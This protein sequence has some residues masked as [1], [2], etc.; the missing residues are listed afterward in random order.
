MTHVITQACVK[1]ASCVPVCPADA[2]AP[3]PDDALFDVSQ[4]LYIDPALC[5]DCGACL[6]A[7]PVAAI[8]DDE[9]ARPDTAPFARLN[10]LHFHWSEDP[11]GAGATA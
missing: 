5:I 11:A 2:I 1:D 6:R 8:R 10:A 9:D 7:C 3:T 4:M